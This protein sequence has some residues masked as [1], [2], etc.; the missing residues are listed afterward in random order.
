MQ[1]RLPN[2]VNLRGSV[3]PWY[4]DETT[5]IYG[6]EESCRTNDRAMDSP[7]LPKNT[8]TNARLGMLHQTTMSR[9][10]N[11]RGKQGGVEGIN[12]LADQESA[13]T[14]GTREQ[15]RGMRAKTAR[16]EERGRDRDRDRERGREREE[17]R[18]RREGGRPEEKNKNPK[19][20]MGAVE[21]LP[22]TMAYFAAVIYDSRRSPRWLFCSPEV[23]L[24]G[25]RHL[26]S[27]SSAGCGQS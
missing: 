9:A 26:A 18:R 6:V 8:A 2:G 24:Q 27:C 5:E 3:S 25:E 13:R 15:G 21:D 12:G 10:S 19:E 23:S 22:G 20:S 17:R 11:T 4:Q 16:Y 14:S 1:E 7:M